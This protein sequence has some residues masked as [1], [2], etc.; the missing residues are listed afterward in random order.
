MIK[1]SSPLIVVIAGPNG[2]GKL[3]EE[4]AIQDRESWQKLRE[5][6]Q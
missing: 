5:M 6:A 3:H 1:A 2:A 4:P